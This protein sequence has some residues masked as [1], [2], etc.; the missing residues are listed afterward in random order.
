M[1]KKGNWFRFWFHSCAFIYLWWQYGDMATE[2]YISMNYWKYRKFCQWYGDFQI[3]SVNKTALWTQL[4]FR[5][6]T[7]NLQLTKKIIKHAVFYL[8]WFGKKIMYLFHLHFDNKKANKWHQMI[9][10][11]ALGTCIGKLTWHKKPSSA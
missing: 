11:G 3:N 6:R 7:C 9:K 5:S 4:R 2:R 1:T 8:S 10:I